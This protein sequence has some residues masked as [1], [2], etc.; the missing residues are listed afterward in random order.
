M[1]IYLKRE[2]NKQ[3]VNAVAKSIPKDCKHPKNQYFCEYLFTA[4]NTIT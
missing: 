4:Q 2:R 1:L 3:T